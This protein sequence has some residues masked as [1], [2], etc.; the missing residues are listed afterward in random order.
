MESATEALVV[1]RTGDTL[2]AES[3]PTL[4]ALLELGADDLDVSLLKPFTKKKAANPTNLEAVRLC[5]H[6]LLGLLAHPEWDLLTLGRP[7]RTPRKVVSALIDLLY[8][9]PDRK[10]QRSSEETTETYVRRLP[11]LEHLLQWCRL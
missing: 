8:H 7:L 5:F 4:L 1:L 6:G 10:L 3:I 2:G 9:H 11:P